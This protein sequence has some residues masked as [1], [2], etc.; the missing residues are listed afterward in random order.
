MPRVA[1]STKTHIER[2]LI[3]VL[4][5]ALSGLWWFT[6][7]KIEESARNDR[8]TEERLDAIDRAL[9]QLEAHQQII[10]RDIATVGKAVEKSNALIVAHLQNAEL[11]ERTEAKVNRTKVLVGQEI[12]EAIMPLTSELRDVKIKL[13]RLHEGLNSRNK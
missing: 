12:R 6:T 9:T 10:Q 2:V 8:K 4:L 3:G 7:D 13:E 11:H 1:D 5:L